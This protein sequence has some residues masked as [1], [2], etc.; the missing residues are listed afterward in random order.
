[1]ETSIGKLLQKF[2]ISWSDGINKVLRKQIAI[3]EPAWTS[4]FRDGHLTAYSIKETLTENIRS[5]QGVV[6]IRGQKDNE[7]EE[8]R[9]GRN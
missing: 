8:T 9:K 5:E 2:V 6:Q 4:Q 3:N 1:M 7:M